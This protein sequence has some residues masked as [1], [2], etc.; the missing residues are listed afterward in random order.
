MC[1]KVSKVDSVIDVNTDL[2]C[3]GVQLFL[4]NIN[5]IHNVYLPTNFKEDN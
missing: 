5:Y 4:C 1:H 2:L 3:V